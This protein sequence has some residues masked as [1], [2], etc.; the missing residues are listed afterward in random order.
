MIV[1]EYGIRISIPRFRVCRS[2]L[3]LSSPGDEVSGGPGGSSLP[4]GSEIAVA[5]F[6]AASRKRQRMGNLLTD[7]R[8]SSSQYN[9]LRILRGAARGLPTMVIRDRMMGREPSITRLV[10]KFEGR[11][12]VKALPNTK[13]RRCVEYHITDSGLRLL[14]ELDHRVDRADCTLIDG[15]S[16]TEPRDLIRRLGIIRWAI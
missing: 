11:R 2:A 12:F 15:F 10:D 14:G 7:H 1:S 8:V 6:Q 16:Q 9:I 5:V 3:E 4:L 13:D